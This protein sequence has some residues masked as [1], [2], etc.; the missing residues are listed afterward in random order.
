MKKKIRQLAYLLTVITFV[1]ILT[2]SCKK[3]ENNN[4]P[5]PPQTVTDIDGNIY[6]TVTIGTQIWMVENLK[7]THYSNGDSIPNVRD[8]TEWGNLTTGAYCNQNNIDSMS[9]TYGRLYN[10]FVVNDN[11]KVAPTGWHI[12][13][14]AEW[15][16]LT[17]YLGG[18]SIVGGKL[19][20]K[21]TIHWAS[22]NIGATNESGFTALPGGYRYPGGS[23]F[24]P[25]G[26]E[27]HWWSS[28]EGYTNCAHNRYIASFNNAVFRNDGGNF[29]GSGFSVRCI[30]DK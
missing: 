29:K 19:K 9:N 11:R 3:D 30:K 16:I 5:T 18:D 23:P 27:G 13:S 17:D 4:N 20:E 14:D 22:P 1:V 25:I 10:W 12:P 6:H 15:T 26:E 2:N 7:V 8:H 21:G 28:T 24:F